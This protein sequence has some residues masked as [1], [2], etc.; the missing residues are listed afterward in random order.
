MINLFT[1]KN[2]IDSK[3]LTIIYICLHLVNFK[4]KSLIIG[5]NHLIFDCIN[6][7]NLGQMRFIIGKL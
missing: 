2:F 7:F 4:I 5:L 1:I 6:Q 3:N